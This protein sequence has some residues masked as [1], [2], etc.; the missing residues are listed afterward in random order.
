MRRRMGRER[1]RFY[2]HPR[3]RGRWSHQ[4]SWVSS[5]LG[6]TAISLSRSRTCHCLFAFDDVKASPRRNLVDQHHIFLPALRG[7]HIATHVPCASRYRS[8]K[9]VNLTDS[10]NLSR[11][12]VFASKP[13][14]KDRIPR[15]VP[16]SNFS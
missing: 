13:S 15:I 11:V 6:V 16:I 3:K 12:I 5:S 4:S 1:A 7:V 10:L 2:I 14:E 8:W 9:R